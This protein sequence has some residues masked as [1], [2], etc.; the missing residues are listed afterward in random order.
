MVEEKI[1]NEQF[2]DD[3]FNDGFDYIINLMKD[4]CWLRFIRSNDYRKLG[5][6]M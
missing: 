3:I 2:T 1:N 4:D 5:M 6:I